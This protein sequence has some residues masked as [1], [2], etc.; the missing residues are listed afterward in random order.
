MIHGLDVSAVRSVVSIANSPGFLVSRLRAMPIVAELARVCAED[1]LEDLAASKLKMVDPSL[2]DV[3]DIYACIIALSMNSKFSSV[4]R[5]SELVD[6]GAML[7]AV[8]SSI[9]SNA[10][11]ITISN[12][13]PP[14]KIVLGDVPTSSITAVS[15]HGN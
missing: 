8:F 12:F 14:S 9:L 1:E 4:R 2:E 15:G 5:L 11:P 10:M 13:T 3:A 6:G 7:K